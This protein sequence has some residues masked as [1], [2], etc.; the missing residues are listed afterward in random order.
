[1]TENKLKTE[2]NSDTYERLSLGFIYMYIYIYGNT[3]Q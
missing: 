2:Y 3:V 1:M